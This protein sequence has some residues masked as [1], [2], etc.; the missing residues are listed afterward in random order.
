MDGWMHACIYVFMY[1]C[2]YAF[3]HLCIYVFMH[4]CMYDYVCMHDIGYLRGPPPD[5][6]Q[7]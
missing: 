7:E 4:L 5:H 2:I 6:T 1:L 3:M